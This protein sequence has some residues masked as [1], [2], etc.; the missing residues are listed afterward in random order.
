MEVTI[1]L[2]MFFVL[3][4]TL[5][6]FGATSITIPV[7]FSLLLVLLYLF[8]TKTK[9][10]IAN[11]A[12]SASLFAVGLAY[13][14]SISSSSGMFILKS[15]SEVLFIGALFLLGRIELSC[16]SKRLTNFSIAML[17]FILMSPFHALGEGVFNKPVFP[18]IEPSHFSIFLG[19]V[20]FLSV[21]YKVHVSKS[22]SVLCLFIIL[23]LYTNLMALI[24]IATI[25]CHLVYRKHWLLAVFPAFVLVMFLFTP[26]ASSFLPNELYQRISLSEE[27]LSSLV[28]LSGIDNILSV[29]REHKLFGNGFASL[30]YVDFD[31]EYQSTIMQ[32]TGSYINLYD[33][34][35][36]FSKLVYQFGIFSVFYTL[37]LLM[38][39]FEV[40]NGRAPKGYYW[41]I[42]MFPVEFF[43]RSPGLISGGFVLFY[44]VCNQWYYE[45]NSN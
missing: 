9:L 6:F 22:V 39:S 21:G 13:I 30:G 14:L 36:I 8:L 27:N 40:L 24:V 7:I 17:I 3:P 32:L 31:N 5:M 15:F 34:S 41:S 18:F 43:I 23:V 28:Y 33:G 35:F 11:W 19:Y 1:F 26:V 25:V 45:K 29:F 16:N 20:Y 2:F 4:E 10:P 44:M 38:I 12:A 37:I 42:L